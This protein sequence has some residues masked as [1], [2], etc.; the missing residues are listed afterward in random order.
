MNIKLADY[1]ETA[2]RHLQLKIIGE[3]FVNSQIS[4]VEHK[5]RLKSIH[6]LLDEHFQSKGMD[7]DASLELYLKE[8]TFGNNL[9]KQEIYRKMDKSVPGDLLKKYAL[10]CV[11]NMDEYMFFRSNFIATYG[12][13]NFFSYLIS[14]GKRH[15]K[16]I[17]III[18]MLLE[19]MYIDPA[20]GSFFYT[21]MKPT[22][23][24]QGQIQK[25]NATQSIRISK[26]FEVRLVIW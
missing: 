6:D 4:L 9:A 12:M 26:N 2:V 14:N 3:Y 20:K 15:K 8:N 18:E 5:T 10:K 21:A 13:E 11:N 23:N 22:F 16:E 25:G 24:E 1:K 17:L 7:N 19:N